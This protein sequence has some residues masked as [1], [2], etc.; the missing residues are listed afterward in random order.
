M[1]PALP[2]RAAGL[3]VEV[4][5][6][7]LLDSLVFSAYPD[8]GPALAALR[9]DGWALVVVSNW[10]AS[11]HER[12]V[13]TGLA[14]LVDGAVASA[15]LGVAK[16]DPAIFAHALE[17]VGA[18]ADA[19]WHVGDTPDVDVAGARAAGLRPVL[20]ARAGRPGNARGVPVLEDL[21]ALP[22]LLRDARP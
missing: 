19:S 17:L 20:V 2:P 11:L 8:A 12:L 7:A 13:E 14:P 18:A 15:E 5:T 9:A 4:L 6:A 3:P 22:R 21:G 10:D 16:P 1:R